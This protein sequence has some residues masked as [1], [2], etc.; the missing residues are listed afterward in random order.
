MWD[1]IFQS[2]VF[3]GSACAAAVVVLR[4]WSF[5]LQPKSKIPRIGPKPGGFES[6]GGF[7]SNSL[8]MIQEGYA[9]V[10]Y[11]KVL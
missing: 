1:F 4:Y 6:N 10:S 8:E 3:W 9:R 7:Y 5:W 11:Y 2:T